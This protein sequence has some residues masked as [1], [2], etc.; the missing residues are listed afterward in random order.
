MDLSPPASTSPGDKEKLFLEAMLE[1][2]SSNKP[3]VVPVLR[4]SHGAVQRGGE[5][6]HLLAAHEFTQKRGEASAR[7]PDDDL[8]SAIGIAAASK[9]CRN[10]SAQKRAAA[11]ATTCAGAYQEAGHPR[12]AASRRGPTPPRL[13]ISYF[14]TSSPG[15]ALHGAREAPRGAASSRPS[16]R[17]CR[18]SSRSPRRRSSRPRSK[19]C[20]LA[21]RSPIRQRVRSRSPRQASRCYILRAA[22][23]CRYARRIR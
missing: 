7:L 1:R 18:C 19:A 20:G 21:F 8:A 23:A 6:A 16:P 4:R 17:R 14:T 15:M 13:P 2:Y 3:R 22:I 10:G 5:D 9:P 11:R 12:R